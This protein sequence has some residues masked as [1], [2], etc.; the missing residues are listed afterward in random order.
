DGEIQNIISS[1]HESGRIFDEE[2]VAKADEMD[3]RWTTAWRNFEIGAK[4]AILNTITNLDSLED[5]MGEL[6]N[7]PFFKWLSQMAGTSG[8]KFVPGVGIVNPTEGV[9]SMER[10]VQVLSDQVENLK[11]LGFDAT[12]AQRELAQAQADLDAE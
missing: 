2:L 12:D 4:A 1:A 9:S 11:G 3:R 7:H 6:G 8:A 10:R 5:A